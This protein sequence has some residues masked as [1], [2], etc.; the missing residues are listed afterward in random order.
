MPAVRVGGRAPCAT[1]APVRDRRSPNQPPAPSAAPRLLAV[2]HPA[3]TN[4]NQ[5]VYRELARRGWE[6]TIVVPRRWRHDYSSAP[7]TPTAL[8]GLEGALRPTPVAFAGRQQRHLYLA[9]CRALA[10]R[11][12]ADVAFVE[13]E[14]YALAA[15][16]WRR[17]LA[18]LGIPWGVQC[19][20]NIDRPLPA[21][22]RRLRAT[23]L[24]DAAFVAARS[25]SA[26]RLAAV[27]GARGEIGLAPPAVPAWESARAADEHANGHTSDPT[28]K[29][30]GACRDATR[31]GG[32]RDVGA[33]AL[34]DSACL[35]GPREAGAGER[36]DRRASTRPFTIGYAGRLVQSK[37]L[38]D[39]LAA[40]R[41]LPAPVELLLIGNGELRPQ[42]EGQ[43]IPGGR[44]RIIDH[45]THARMAE[46]YA[47][48]DVLALPSRTT[49]TWKEQLGRAIVEALWCGVPVVGSDSGEIP[50]LIEL[51]GGGLTFPEGDA[52]ALAERLGTLRDDPAL[53]LRFARAG[54]ETA[55]R[56][57]SVSAATDA[58]ERLLVGAAPSCATPAQQ[59]TAMGIRFDAATAATTIT[60][61]PATSA[62]VHPDTD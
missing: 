61:C 48:L 4:V 50:W 39:L 27:W 58:L 26:A 10:A 56:I 20:E 16:Q 45:L 40:V 9:R 53:R 31:D 42:L 59:R 49:P 34:S 11:A 13:A 3:V 36:G 57:F 51:T 8:R 12:R 14:P 43:P 38:L 54:R 2:S 25:R 30:D 46:G 29:D 52:A 18:G 22:V 19:Y 17:A 1:M 23:V 32:A 35:G 60:A 15:A 6:V 62:A 47:Q 7:V 28:G 55:E 21:P 37:G 5:G 24:R 33:P 41:R 44:V